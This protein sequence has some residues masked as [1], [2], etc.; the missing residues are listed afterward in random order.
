MYRLKQL[1]PTPVETL[2]L[3][4]KIAREEGLHYVYVGNV[5]GHPATDT[6]CPECGKTLIRRKG[7]F[8][9]ENCLVDGRCPKCR[10][11]IPGI[12]AGKGST[13]AA[14]ESPRPGRV[15]A[16]SRG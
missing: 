4:W 12:F 14:P 9:E 7:L 10:T 3:A 15:A 16:P 1:P 11:L 6:I 8:V 13:K 5:P 2:D